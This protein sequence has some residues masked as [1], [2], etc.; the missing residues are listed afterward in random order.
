VRSEGAV[1]LLLKPLAAAQR[2]RNRIY[3][4]IKG[5]ATNHGGQA[6]G[7]TVPS[8]MRQAELGRRAGRNAQVDPA[9]ITYVEA[10]GTGTALGDPVEV[11]GLKEAFTDSSLAGQEKTQP[12]CGLGS[13]KTNLGHLE[14]AAGITGLLKVL[15]CMHHRK[16]PASLNFRELNP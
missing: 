11:K 8:P 6:S 15:L 14:A 5:S 7:L 10:H 16:I 12:Y 13:I 3:A 9:T 4:V 1:V 2:E